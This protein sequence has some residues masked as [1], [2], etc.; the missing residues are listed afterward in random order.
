MVEANKTDV[1]DTVVE[2]MKNFN[3]PPDL[4][5]PLEVVLRE[6]AHI[7][8]AKPGICTLVEQT[9]DT[10]DSRP[11]AC[12]PRPM[13]IAK[14]TTFQ[15][16]FQKILDNDII[17]PCS[18]SW[19]SACVIVPKRD[20]DGKEK[21]ENAEINQAR[22][23]GYYNKGRVH[24]NFKIGDKVLLY[25]LTLS[26][27]AKGITASLCTKC[28]GQF[29]IVDMTSR[30]ICTLTCLKTGKVLG[31]LHVAKLKPF[32]SRDECPKSGFSNGD[33]REEVSRGL[34]TDREKDFFPAMEH[35]MK[36]MSVSGRRN[37]WWTANV[38][39]SPRAY[40]VFENSI[41]LTIETFNLASPPRVMKRKPCQ[42]WVNKVE[43]SL[44]TVGNDNPLVNCVDNTVDKT[45]SNSQPAQTTI[46]TNS[47]NGVPECSQSKVKNVAS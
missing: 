4:I 25:S 34:C 3:L 42:E 43:T 31:T 16:L 12:N 37:F 30:Q 10:G 41:S 40:R 22:S 5:E 35:R 14:R 6:F 24:G 33:V 23:L 7:F 18:G 39:Y 32:Y 47:K 26:N 28:K 2:I 21:E 19:V 8:T 27:A 46:Q 36:A 1:T 45:L 11:I 38:M 29:E 13:T 17:K 20:G 15:N 9:I 44:R